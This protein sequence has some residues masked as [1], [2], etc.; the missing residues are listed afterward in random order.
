MGLR[1]D[2]A[3]LVANCR[4]DG[5]APNECVSMLETDLLDAY[6]WSRNDVSL[7][8]SLDKKSLTEGF[9]KHFD[10]DEQYPEEWCFVQSEGSMSAECSIVK[11]SDNEYEIRSGSGRYAGTSDSLASAQTKAASMFNIGISE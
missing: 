10:A 7:S 11:Y 6:N 4:R 2:S 9:W 3:K 8:E 5:D 1:E